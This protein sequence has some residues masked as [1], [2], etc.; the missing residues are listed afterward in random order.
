MR[1]RSYSYTKV[2]KKSGR[3]DEVKNLV[4][5]SMS[6]ENLP[7]IITPTSAGL[8]FSESILNAE[9][10]EFLERQGKTN[11][12]G[13]FKKLVIG[14][15]SYHFA[16][17]GD[18]LA[19]PKTP[20]PKAIT[21]MSNETEERIN[22]DEIIVINKLPSALSTKENCDRNVSKRGLLKRQSRVSECHTS[23]GHTSD[24]F[25]N[26]GLFLK[27]EHSIHDNSE[28]VINN[29]D[30]N[31]NPSKFRDAE[32]QTENCQIEHETIKVAEAA[33][34]VA[35]QSLKLSL[36]F[37]RIQSMKF[38]KFLENNNQSVMFNNEEFLEKIEKI[39]KFGDK[40]YKEIMKMDE[41]LSFHL[42]MVKS[43]KE[44]DFNILNEAKIFIETLENVSEFLIFVVNLIFIFLLFIFLVDQIASRR[45]FFLNGFY[46][47]L[48]N[49]NVI[50]I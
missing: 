7:E 21:P 35:V 4:D 48:F 16:N 17:D 9:N 32:C 24:N 38:A 18:P 6:N 42:T 28:F 29:V 34:T 25:L 10:R 12:R 20:S 41:L 37:Y 36:E 33:F 50:V 47:V 40:M 44:I 27:P 31:A 1:Q 45:K 22:N 14:E 26:S 46:Q 3:K 23:E 30:Y 39:S 19:F 13:G 2:Q 8:S 5:K 11:S 49:Q 43:S 15:K